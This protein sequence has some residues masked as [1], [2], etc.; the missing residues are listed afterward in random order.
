MLEV[1]RWVSLDFLFASLSPTPRSPKPNSAS[2]RGLIPYKKDEKFM[3]EKLQGESSPAL[4]MLLGG[5]G[6]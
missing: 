3:E 6:L 2:P 5:L 1:R 4:L